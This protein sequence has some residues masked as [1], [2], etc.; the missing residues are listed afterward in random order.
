MSSESS[1]EVVVIGAGVAGAA[2]AWELARRGHRVTLLEQFALDHVLGS[3][4]GRSR[5]FRLAYDTADYVGL[6]QEALH[7]WRELEEDSGHDLLRITGAVDIG[8][9]ELLEPIAAA[10]TERG[11]ESS[12]LTDQDLGS[13]VRAPEGWKA[14]YQPLG[15]VLSARE[16]LA[17]F[18]HGAVRMGATVLPDAKAASVVPEVDHVD[19]DTDRGVFAAEVAVIAAGGWANTL[20]QPLGLDVPLKVTREHV[21]YFRIAPEVEFL[22]FIWHT[23]DGSPEA[24]GLPNAEDGTAKVGRHLAG[25]QV[26]PGGRGSPDPERISALTEFV[27]RHLP[28]LEPKALLPETC[29]YASTPDDDFVIERHGRVILAVGFGG[30]GFKFGPA[31][32]AMVAE[33]VEGRSIELATRFSRGRFTGAVAG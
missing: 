15:G 32:G 17:A 10:L 22:P 24:Y 6:A 1:V 29:L 5:I 23:D 14:L 11:A 9:R 7:G 16:C 13:A 33:L 12:W 31:I 27:G 4:H 2:A 30:H 8:P 19:V 20:L 26:R 18:A 28:G 25:Q 21:A 3:S